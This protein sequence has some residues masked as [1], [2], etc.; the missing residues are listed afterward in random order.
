MPY[1]YPALGGRIADPTAATKC[2]EL[3]DF[4]RMLY[5]TLIAQYGSSLNSGATAI[6]VYVQ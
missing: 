1:G 5:S 3:C 4:G 6:A 2:H